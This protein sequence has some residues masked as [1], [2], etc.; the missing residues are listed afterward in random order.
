MYS[1]S[2]IALFLGIDRQNINSYIKKGHLKATKKNGLYRISEKDYRKFRDD[3]YDSGRRNSNRGVRRR[4]QQQD[5]DILSNML[6]DIEN[7][8]LSSKEF[9]DKYEQ[10]KYDIPS[11]KDFIEYYKD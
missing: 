5:I 8:N 2:E 1:T 11:V 6:E 10:Y 3:Y 7:K 9:E 4:L